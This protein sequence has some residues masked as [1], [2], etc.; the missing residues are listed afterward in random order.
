M[1]TD[2]FQPNGLSVTPDDRY[3]PDA[4]HE[5]HL[6]SGR[7][8]NVATTGELPG[9]C[10]LVDSDEIGRDV[11]SPEFVVRAGVTTAAQLRV[12]TRH[13]VNG[14][15]FSVQT[16]PGLSGEALAR[17][18]RFPN[19]QISVT[20]V[21]ELRRI[22]VTVIAPTTGAGAHHG[23]VVIPDPPPPGLFEAISRCFT[24]RANPFV[25]S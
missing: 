16:A 12:G 5:T 14:H 3:P 11:Q 1:A 24:Q 25:A 17:G 9:H 15:G 23:T 18:G 19:R 6:G 13:S 21:E 8:P 22:G 7:P 2:L 10:A 4:F 20:T